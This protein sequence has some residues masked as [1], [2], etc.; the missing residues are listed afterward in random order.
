MSP[1]FPLHTNGTTTKRNSVG[2]LRNPINESFINGFFT[3]NQ[4]WTV[5][6]WNKA[7]EKI[8]GVKAKDIVGK[9]LWQEFAAILPL[10]FY[11]VYHKAFQQKSPFHFEEYW[12]E[13]GAWFD[14]V[15]FYE[16]DSLFVSFKSNDQSKEPADTEKPELQLLVLNDLYRFIS[17]V[18]NDCLWE[19]DLG[20]REI[21]WIDGGHKKKFGYP[22]ENALIPQGFWES[23]LHPEDKAGVLA[24]LHKMIEGATGNTW[25]DEYRFRKANGGYAYVHDRGH[26]IYNEEKTVVRMI[27]ATQDITSRVLLENKLVRERAAQQKEITNAV[28]T[29]LEKERAGIGTELHD[30]LNQLLAI[31]KLYV[32]MAKK[33]TKG[34]KMYLDKSTL[35]ISSVIDEIR[36]IS[37]MLVVPGTHNIGLLDNIENLLYELNHV[38]PVKIYFQYDSIDEKELDNKLQLTIFRIV[39]EQINNI[40]KHAEATEAVIHLSRQLEPVILSISDNGKGCQ[41]TEVKEGVGLINIK[42]RAEMYNGTMTTTSQPGKG[43]EL[44]VTLWP[45]P[46]AL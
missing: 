10:E 2:Y 6:Y 24:R 32:Q 42:A 35:L 37:R 46:I 41:L 13:M 40:L 23:R 20:S 36:K 7:A 26:I 16:N 11:S 14:V 4:K 8:L 45:E 19:W 33:D 25:E 5:T 17:E 31:A 9:N 29:A 22:I 27:G 1:G 38:Q 34:R 30:N 21:F 18:T 15:T 28:L 44:K 39:Q 43:F 12:G 3:V